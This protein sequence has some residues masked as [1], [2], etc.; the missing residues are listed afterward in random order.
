MTNVILFHNHIPNLATR[1]DDRVADTY[2]ARVNIENILSPHKYLETRL[3]NDITGT[4]HIRFD[5][6]ASQTASIDFIAIGDFSALK[7]NGITELK[8]KSSSDNSTYT[9]RYVGSV[10]SMTALGRGDYAEQ[11]AASSAYRYWVFETSSGSASYHRFS[12]VFFGN[13]L[14]LGVD[15]DIVPTLLPP[16]TGKW[17]SPSGALYQIRIGTERYRIECRWEGVSDANTAAF[18]QKI[19]APRESQGVFLYAPSYTHAL[20]GQTLL[21]CRCVQASQEQGNGKTDWNIIRA[22]FEEDR[23]EAVADA[24]GG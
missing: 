21:Y 11:F 6:G 24:G 20:D 4:G 17:R 13:A 10:G 7:D 19:V 15:P 1:I 3:E 23:S 5:L 16:E 2:P 8:L 12:K 14:D 9:D 22:V 18:F